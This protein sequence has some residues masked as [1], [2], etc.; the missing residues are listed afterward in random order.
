MSGVLVLGRAPDC[1][2]SVLNGGWQGDFIVT[3]KTYWVVPL[4]TPP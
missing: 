4:D 1:K 3:G 2:F